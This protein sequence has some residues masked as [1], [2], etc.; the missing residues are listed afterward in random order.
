LRRRIV[1]FGK[2]KVEERRSKIGPKVWRQSSQEWR[3]YLLFI[4]F[5]L[6]RRRL[7]LREAQSRQI[8]DYP[9]KLAGVLT[10]RAGLKY[11]WRDHQVA[12]RIQ[13]RDQAVKNF[14]SLFA[15]RPNA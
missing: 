10:I 13:T 14:Y 4:E 7:L 5:G 2:F 12:P 1:L 8:A 11:K 3:G 9:I 15:K 6:L